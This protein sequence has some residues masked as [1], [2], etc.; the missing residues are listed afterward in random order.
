MLFHY[1]I[2]FT[3]GGIRFFSAFRWS[4]IL[5]TFFDKFSLRKVHFVKI[6]VISLN[7]FLTFSPG[8]S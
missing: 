5:R 1:L 7:L 4:E 2:V 3:L 6:P 8:F